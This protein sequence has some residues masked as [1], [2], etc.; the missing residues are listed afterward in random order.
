MDSLL[1]VQPFERER[2]VAVQYAETVLYIR[3]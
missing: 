2:I 1:A 3:R